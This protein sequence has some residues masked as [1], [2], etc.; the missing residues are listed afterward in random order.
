M[1]NSSGYCFLGQSH[2]LHEAVFISIYTAFKGVVHHFPN[3]ARYLGAPRSSPLYCVRGC[4][5]SPSAWTSPGLCPSFHPHGGSFHPPYHALFVLYTHWTLVTLSSRPIFHSAITSLISAMR[6]QAEMRY[7]VVIP[8]AVNSFD[9]QTITEHTE[10]S[11][12]ASSVSG[13]PYIPCLAFFLIQFY[14]NL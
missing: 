10:A 5:C 8:H 3:P 7:F 12:S 13:A 4:M 1:R 6:R 2:S 14:L 9:L 11:G